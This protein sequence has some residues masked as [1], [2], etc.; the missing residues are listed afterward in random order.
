MDQINSNKLWHKGFVQHI[1]GLPPAD[2]RNGV[3][4]SALSSLSQLKWSSFSMCLVLSWKTRLDTMHST[5]WHSQSYGIGIRVEGGVNTSIIWSKNMAATTIPLLSNQETQ[6]GL[7][8]S[9]AGQ[10]LKTEQKPNIFGKMCQISWNWPNEYP[11][12]EGSVYYIL[13]NEYSIQGLI[14]HIPIPIHANYT[15]KY[16]IL[17]YS[18]AVCW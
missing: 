3:E 6:W 16:I 7:S 5:A 12:L 10:R 11:G 8:F 13:Y 1:C 4:I 18:K 15:W 14:F 2:F 9:N 17:I